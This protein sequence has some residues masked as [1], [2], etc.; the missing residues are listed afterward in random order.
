MIG[1]SMNKKIFSTNVIDL[2]WR[3]VGVNLRHSLEAD[4]PFGKIEISKR[5]L[6][7]DYLLKLPDCYG[8]Q[9]SINCSG[10]DDAQKKASEELANRM[11]KLLK[12]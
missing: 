10:P 9:T 3:R 1:I 5:Y 6:G 11:N 12:I 8:G 2:K 7:Q 4:T